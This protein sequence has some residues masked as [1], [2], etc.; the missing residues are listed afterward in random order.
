[1]KELYE[2]NP[3]NVTIKN[4]LA[5]SYY[6]LGGIYQDKQQAQ[7]MYNQAIALWQELYDLT[8]LETYKG[9]IETVKQL[10]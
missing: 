10:V 3:K 2:S 6:K 8:K 9:Y 7:A 4:G 5:I 1:M